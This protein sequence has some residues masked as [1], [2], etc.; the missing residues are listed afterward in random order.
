MIP[1]IPLFES[2]KNYT[3]KTENVNQF[4][5]S[6]CFI[7]QKGIDLS[8]FVVLQA[9]MAQIGLKFGDLVLKLA[10][11]V[12]IVDGGTVSDEI[13]NNVETY[14]GE[15]D[16]SKIYVLSM[17][18]YNE[19]LKK[20]NPCKEIVVVDEKV[21]DKIVGFAE[22]EKQSCIIFNDLHS[23]TAGGVLCKPRDFKGLHDRLKAKGATQLYFL[24]SINE[25]LQ[26]ASGHDLILTISKNLDGVHPTIR[27]ALNS[28]AAHLQDTILPM[29]LELHRD[30]TGIWRVETSVTITDQE[31]VIKYFAKMGKTYA[32][33]AATIGGISAS[34][35][36]RRLHAMQERGEIKIIGHR[37][38]EA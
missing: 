34:T 38:Y 35:V 15:K 9:I 6:I 31:A 8:Y 28:S 25:A 1:E 16:L 29:E 13:W 7:C 36:G 23:L 27:V 17:K 4:G 20:K 33:I 32:E 30:Q 26:I 14:S 10:T 12:M 18:S 37:V 11:G 22:S 2:Y 21:V 24:N 19:K 3:E 5:K